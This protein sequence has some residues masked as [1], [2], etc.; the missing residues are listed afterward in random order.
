[1][2]VRLLVIFIIIIPVFIYSAPERRLTWEPVIGAWGYN[3]EIKD[4]RNNIVLV[5]AVTV[6]YIVVSQLEPG[7]YA[8]RV[9]TLNILKQ[10][11]ETTEW[12]D[13]VIE[14]LYVPELTSVSDRQL[15]TSFL[16]KNIVVTGKNLKPGCRLL[17]R[18]NGKEIEISDITVKSDNEVIFSFK[19]DSS[20]KGRYD[21]A[22]INRGEAEAV[23]KDAVEIVEPEAAKTTFYAGAGYT[24]NIPFGTWS[25]YYALSYTG[26]RAF[27]QISGRNFGFENNLFEMELDAVRYSNLDSLRKSTL[28]Y[29]AFGIGSGYYYPLVTNSLEI[30]F[31]LAGGGV[32]SSVT[33]DE[34]PSAK[35][36]TSIDVYIMTGAGIRAYIS[37]SIFVDSTCSWKTVFYAEEFLNE[38]GISLDC[39]TKF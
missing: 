13:F 30:F 14:K 23:L 6:N 4:S 28:S 11:G 33:F 5:T 3:V 20:L 19:P 17:L 38:A 18:G 12:I 1:M 36:M 16:N 39:G 32:Y 9:A 8:F 35:K 25:D 31:K 27:F 7:A 37:D 21:L 26:V 22:L 10:K 34:D 29:A 24:V 2:K 15:L